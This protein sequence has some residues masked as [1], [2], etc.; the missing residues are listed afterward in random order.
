MSFKSALLLGVVERL[1]LRQAVNLHHRL[2]H[3]RLGEPSRW[4][5]LWVRFLIAAGVLESTYAPS[6][7][8]I[9]TPA[10]RIPGRES[11]YSWNLPKKKKNTKA[12]T[13]GDRCTFDEEYQLSLY[14][15]LPARTPLPAAL[16]PLGRYHP[17]VVGRHWA[18]SG[19]ASGLTACHCQVASP[20]SL[21]GPFFLTS[22]PSSSLARLRV[23]FDIPFS[24][25]AS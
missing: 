24:F 10:G 11:W 21:S 22:M 2:D 12:L 17:V 14:G 3:V 20:L 18:G 1:R 19:P 13:L 8:R 16:S 9:P 6:R 5:L 15:I 25:A 7:G 4:R 23:I